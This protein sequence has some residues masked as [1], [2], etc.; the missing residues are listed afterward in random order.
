MMSVVDSGFS[1]TV[2]D[3]LCNSMAGLTAFTLDMLLQSLPN[4][5]PLSL[6][7]LPASLSCPHD[8]F[9]HL[10]SHHHI[11]TII[12]MTNKNPT[13]VGPAIIACISS[14]QPGLVL[15]TRSRLDLNSSKLILSWCISKSGIFSKETSGNPFTIGSHNSVHLLVSVD[16]NF[17]KDSFASNFSSAR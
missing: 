14:S 2:V 9:A 6:G 1:P 16:T 15:L 17:K 5:I 13:M 10:F 7:Y 3:S 11:T 8:K 4:G 12:R